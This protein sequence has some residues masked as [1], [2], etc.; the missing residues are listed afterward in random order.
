M[1]PNDP[2]KPNLDEPKQLVR[3]LH[4]MGVPLNLLF[5]GVAMLLIPHYFP[6]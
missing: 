5:W 1:D 2:M 3:E 4:E 6:F